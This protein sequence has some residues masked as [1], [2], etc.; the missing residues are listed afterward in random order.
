MI[1]F[2]VNPRAGSHGGERLLRACETVLGRAALPYSVQQ[3]ERPGQGTELARAAVRRGAHVVVAAGGDGTIQEVVNGIVGTETALAVLPWGTGNGLAHQLRMSRDPVQLCRLLLGGRVATIDVGEVCGRYFVNVA[4]FGYDAEVVRR[5][6]AVMPRSLKVIRYLWAAVSARLRH[7]FPRLRLTA[8]GR[9]FEVSPWVSCV[10][11]GREYGAGCVIAPR[12][13]L[14]DGQLDLALFDRIGVVRTGFALPALFR[15][16]I[17]RHPAYRTV[18][19]RELAVDADEPLPVEA[20]GELVG[21]TPCLVRIHPLALRVVVPD[22][23]PPSISGRRLS[24][25]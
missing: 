1:E 9:T 7:R 24:A 19:V 12:A 3:T 23:L 20:D 25:L 16:V 11:N 21:E 8:D 22:P 5:S 17:D 13:V 14:D 6:L 2:V 10:A 4:G 15:G 18:P